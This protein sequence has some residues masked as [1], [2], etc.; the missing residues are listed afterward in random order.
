MS[1]LQLLP[2]LSNQGKPTGGGAD[3]ITLIPSQIRVK[4]LKK[5]REQKEKKVRVFTFYQG[6]PTFNH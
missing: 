3:K 2:F 6:V 4:R 1:G 5:N